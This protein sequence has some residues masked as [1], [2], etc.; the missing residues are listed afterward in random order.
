VAKLTPEAC[1]AARALLGWGVRDLAEHSG[2]NYVTITRFEN[3]TT[4]RESTEARLVAAFEAH[5]VE[6]T[7]GTGTGAR[8]LSDG[9][10]RPAKVKALRPRKKRAKK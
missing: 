7:N 3:G 9:P 6:I 4:S 1:R 8:L 5:G 2:V 10:K